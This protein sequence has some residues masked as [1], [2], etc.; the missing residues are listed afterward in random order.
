MFGRFITSALLIGV[1]I[2]SPWLVSDWLAWRESGT[3]PGGIYRK[4]GE[5]PSN[6]RDR[7]AGGGEDSPGREVIG[8]LDGEESELSAEPY[9]LASQTFR[10]LQGFLPSGEDARRILNTSFSGAD[11]SE[12]EYPRNL[13]AS[14]LASL[15]TGVEGLGLAVGDP[16]FLRVFKEEGELEVWMQG[17][18][19]S[20][21]TLFKVYR[22]NG[23]SGS[24]GPKI[25]EGDRQ[26]PE[27]FYYISSSRMRP[28]TKHHLGMD[29]GFPNE[30]DQFHGRS[31]SDLMIHGGGGGSGAFVLNPHDMTEIHSLAESALRGGQRLF[32]VNIF[33]FRMTDRRMNQEWESQPDWID[34]WVNLKEGYDFFENANF[35]PD[36]SIGG[37][38]YVFRFP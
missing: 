33:P 21:F 38:E 15:S 29:L 25:K 18:G 30:Y 27:G 36:V 19:D 11:V 14:G 8:V 20:H 32:R 13:S 5:F 26:M 22:I 35:P 24:L 4:L 28:D 12:A 1:G 6:L 31:G 17:D 10:M 9:P 7:F 37:G 3:P 2:A 34:F 16:V 23:W